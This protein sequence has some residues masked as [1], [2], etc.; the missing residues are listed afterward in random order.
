MKT[1]KNFDYDLWT[2]AEN[3]CM[4]RVKATGE[5]CVVSREVLRFLQTEDKRLR[6]AVKSKSTQLVKGKSETRLTT[7]SLDF[8]CIENG[9][10]V[11]S[12][13][14]EDPR[15]TEDDVQTKV[16]EEEIVADLTAAQYDVYLKCLKSGMSLRSY[17]REKK[18]AFSTVK[19]IQ[20]SIRK[21]F[22]KIFM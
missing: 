5:E 7:I 3:L 13:W 16:L 6:R 20:D 4:V 18:L 22:Q 21:K 9:E 17:A 1:P 8:V 11:E 14:L 12:S 15:K 19:G 10:C 2:T